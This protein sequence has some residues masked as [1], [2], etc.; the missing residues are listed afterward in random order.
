MRAE[1]PSAGSFGRV[2]VVGLGVMGGSLVRALAKLPAPPVVSGWSPAEA[3]GAASLA[4]GAVARLGDG[5]EDAVEDAELVVLAAPLGACVELVPRVL[6]VLAPDAV[7]TDVASLKVPVEAAV[8]RAGGGSRWVGSHPMCGSAESGYAA[9]RADLYR[10]APVWVVASDGADDAL[11]RVEALWHALGAS[12]QRIG[13]AD[14]DALMTFSSHLPQLVANA[15]ASALEEAGLDPAALGPGGRDM[16][17]LAGSS[18]EMWRDIFA[19]ALTPRLSGALRVMAD[20]L[21]DLADQAEAGDA[22]AIARLMA[23]TRSWKGGS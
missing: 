22:E 20:R 11:G 10:G 19:H 6:A 18:P 7:L 4:E 15:L 17:R 12:T 2:A 16:T 21:R 3:E 13:A 9:S 14:H 23:A 5:V 1:S 8:S